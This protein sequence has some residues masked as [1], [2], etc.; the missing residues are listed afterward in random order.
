MRQFDVVENPSERSRPHAPYF[1]VLQ[2]HH[3]EPLDS[4]VVAPLLRDAKRS[5]SSLDLDME[6]MGERLVLAVGE[7]SAS[8]A[9]C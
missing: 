3:L 7:L 2:S 4:V 9:A 1:V 5:M 6:V 8:N